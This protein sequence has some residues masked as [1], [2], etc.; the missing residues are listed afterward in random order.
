MSLQGKECQ[1]I[2]NIH[3]LQT[4][5]V[6]RVFIPLFIPGNNYLDVFNCVGTFHQHILALSSP[7]IEEEEDHGFSTGH[8]HRTYQ[9]V[10]E[11][12]I[13]KSKKEERKNYVL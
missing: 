5:W 9:E 1:K 7:I 4:M 3:F 10:E 2:V 6:Q 8:I 11:G 12:R 13:H